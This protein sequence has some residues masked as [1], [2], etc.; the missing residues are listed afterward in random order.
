MSVLV[1]SW[2]KGK[3]LVGALIREVNGDKLKLDFGRS[4]V[5][6]C[7]ESAVRDIGRG[8]ISSCGA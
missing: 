3:K 6:W 4:M 8:M 1:T 7:A 5:S 2:E